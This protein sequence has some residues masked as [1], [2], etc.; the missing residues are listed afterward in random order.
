[1]RLTPLFAVLFAASSRRSFQRRRAAHRAARRDAV[2]DRGRQQPHHADR[3]RV[4]RPVRELAGRARRAPSWCRRT[5]E[6]YASLQKAGLVSAAPATAAAAPRRRRRARCR[7]LRRRW[8]ATPSVPGDTLSGL[9]ADVARVRQRDR[10]DERAQPDRRAARRHRASSC[11]PVRPRRPAP[12]SRRRPPKV[13]P[14]AA[15]EPTATRFGAA[16]VQSVAAPRRLP[17]ARDRDRLAGE[18]LQQRD[19]LLRERPRRHAGHARHVELRP[20]EP[21][22][23]PARPATR[24]ATT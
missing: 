21:R 1:M 2:V 10:R 4:Q 24:R 6:G 22:H 5:V 19:G 23:P 9:A 16:D 15:P 20:A 12:R 7:P 17:L 8:A 14:A 3:R 18:R 11:R 13:V